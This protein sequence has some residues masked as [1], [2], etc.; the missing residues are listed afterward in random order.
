MEITN[1]VK[2]GDSMAHDNPYIPSPPVPGVE[3]EK[4]VDKEVLLKENFKEERLNDLVSKGVEVT[5][6]EELKVKKKQP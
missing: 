5:L 6:P 3:I 2:R 1:N 4:D